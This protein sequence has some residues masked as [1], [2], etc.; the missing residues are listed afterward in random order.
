[1]RYFKVVATHRGKEEWMLKEFNNGRLR[2][3]WGW[4]DCD[5]REI[6]KIPRGD[7]SSNQKKAWRYSQ[8][9]LNRIKIGDRLVIQHKQPLR[10]FLLA[11]V[12]GDYFFDSNPGED[13]NHILSIKPHYKDY[14]D[15]NSKIIPGYLKKALTKRGQYYEI[16]PTDAINKLNEII[17]GRSW[18]SED[19]DDHRKFNDELDDSASEVLETVKKTISKHWKAKDFEKFNENLLQL[20]PGVDVKFA[21][22]R[23]EGYD[24]LIQAT[25]PLTLE[26]LSDQIP[27]QCKAYKGKVNKI[28]AVN[29]IERAI[30][31][32]DSK[33][34]YIAILGDLT[35][36]FRDYV[37]E[38]EERLSN[39]LNEDVKI[40]ILDHDNLARLALMY[41]FFTNSQDI[42]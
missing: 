7:R 34:G 14:I 42:S 13:F 26:V 12:T 2:F 24:L 21:G 39:E 41:S 17:E 32:T 15:L 8:F 31:N 25:D 27:V 37:I 5:L 1:M 40:K 36:Y 22:D 20:I 3:G 30:R 38:T 29:D 23:G 19:Y 11:E 33:L 18:K 10:K 16:Y 9:L 4:K 6:A 35:D 28:E